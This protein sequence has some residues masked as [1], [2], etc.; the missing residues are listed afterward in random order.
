MKEIKT[1]KRAIEVE[2]ILYYI[3]NTG[4]QGWHRT[5][6]KKGNTITYK[7]G[8]MV[9]VFTEKEFIEWVNN[10]VKHLADT[11]MNG[12]YYI[13]DLKDAGLI[14]DPTNPKGLDKRTKEYHEYERKMYKRTIEDAGLIKNK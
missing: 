4:S 11:E 5:L 6:I 10:W 12:N 7:R 8:D 14:N 3:T 1:I 9:D 2:K 13:E